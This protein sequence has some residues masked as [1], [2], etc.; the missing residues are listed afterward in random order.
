MVGSRVNGSTAP[1]RHPH[2]HPGLFQFLRFVTVGL[3][4][5]AVELIVYNALLAIHDPHNLTILTIYSTLGVI[6]AIA[7]SYIFNSRWA[8]RGYRAPAGRT[9]VRQRFLFIA[10]A[11]VNI[12]INDVV[13][14]GL[15]PLL[16]GWDIIPRVAAQNLAKVLAMGTSSVSSYLMLRW[17]VFTRGDDEIDDEIARD[18]MPEE[19]AARQHRLR[20]HHPDS[21]S[22]G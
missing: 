4:N 8:F 22:V 14:V 1:T 5:T 3:L 18:E 6:G 21:E 19:P 7:N 13:T 15:T 17:F 20:R 11:L 9:A 10:Q 2:G 12:G 16:T